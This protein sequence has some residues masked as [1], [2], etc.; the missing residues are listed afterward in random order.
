MIPFEERALLAFFHA[1]SRKTTL[2]ALQELRNHLDRDEQELRELTDQTIRRLYE[3][4]DDD[5]EEWMRQ[6]LP[7]L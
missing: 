7:E 2:Q 3:A 6:P 5:Y 1:N 4:T